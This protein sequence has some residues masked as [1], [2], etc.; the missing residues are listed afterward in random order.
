MVALILLIVI[1]GV[2]IFVHELGHFM[3]AK[4][5]GAYVYEFALGMGPKIFSFKRKKE[6]KDPTEYSLRLFPIKSGRDV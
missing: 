1:L 5:R 2:L 6:K 4:N 3:T